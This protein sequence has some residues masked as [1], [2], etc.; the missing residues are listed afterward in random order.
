[1]NQELYVRKLIK[2]VSTI[3]HLIDQVSDNLVS[4]VSFLD[5]LEG[6]DESV[7]VSD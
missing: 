4:F 5:F 1:M 2:S 7:R 6:V 3:N